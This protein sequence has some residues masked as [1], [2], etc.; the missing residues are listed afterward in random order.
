MVKIKECSGHRWKIF[1]D[2]ELISSNYLSFFCSRCL[3]IVK[4][5]KEYWVETDGKGK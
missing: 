3:V 1:K 2:P 5:K 4:K